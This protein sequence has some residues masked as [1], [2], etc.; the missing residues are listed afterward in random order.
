MFISLVAEKEFEI[1]KH[2]FMLKVLERS[3]IQGPY[4]NIIK[5][6]YYKTTANINLN[7]DILEVI[8]LKS[9]TRQGYS[10]FPYLLNIVLEVLVRTIRQQREIKDIQIGKEIKVSLFSGD[11]IV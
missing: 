8:P 10:L 6:I 11:K 4:L 3:E 7:G 5:G 1:I 2:P 9:G